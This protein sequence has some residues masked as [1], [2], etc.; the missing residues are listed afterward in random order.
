MKKETDIKI[1]QVKI[2]DLLPAAYN[3]RFHG[4]KPLEDL[5]ESI[6]SFGCLDPIICNSAPERKNTVIGGHMRIKAAT[7]LGLTE[8]P[9]VFVNIPDIQKEKELN[10][11]L[12]R[13]TGEW[14]FELLKEFDMNLL[15]DVGFD[16]RDL[17]PIWDQQETESDG[18]DLEKKLEEIKTPTVKPGDL[19]MLGSHFL[20]CGNSSDS[21]QVGRLMGGKKASMVYCD[22]PYNI[23]L[24]YS[25]GISTSGKYGGMETDSKTDDEYREFLRKSIENAI[26]VSEPDAHFFY[27]CDEK[28]IGM[29]QSL[30]QE[31]GI[32]N[33][34]VCLWVKNNL[35]MTPGVAFNKLYEPCV[36]GT[37]GKP[38]LSEKLQ[39]LT[40]ILNKE[41]DTGNRALD[42]ILDLLNIW[43]VKR[44]PGQDYSH[45]TEKPVTLHE[46]PL[47]RCTR[48]GDIVLDLFAGSGSTLMACEQMKRVCYTC[49][50]DPVF[51]QVV[52]E[53]FTETTGIKPILLTKEN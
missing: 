47:R 3:P 25:K 19:Y 16:D 33:K 13:N 14:D 36:Y 17:S 49:E 34:R 35:N 6:R 28:Y 52:L 48:P 23:G 24:N 30:Y 11:R 9:A 8:L 51:C 38:F 32:S 37:T 41:I 43:L 12:N 18:F 1:V 46:K 29:L 39:N 15:L 45:P 27:Y 42:D 44:L 2:A 40:E 26:S 4:E 20:L 50:I 53:R 7:A 31:L 5:K 10:L 21:V 22:S